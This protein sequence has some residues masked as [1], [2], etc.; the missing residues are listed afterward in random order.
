MA[1]PLPIGLRPIADLLEDPDI[2]EIMLNG[3][4]QIFVER[5]GHM[6]KVPNLKLTLEQLNVMVDAMAILAGRSVNYQS[7]YVDL[8]LPDGSRVNIILPPVSIRGPVITIRK[9]SKNFKKID[10]L[11]AKGTLDQRMAN[12][13]IAAIQGRLNVVFAGATGS[14]KTTTL[15]VLSSY[16]ETSDRIL[17]LEDTAE[18]TLNQDHV[19][20]L[21]C[22][23]ASAEGKGE[24][25]IRDLFKNAMRMRPDRII[26]GEVRG[27]EAVEMIQAMVSGHRGT[28][29]VLHAG[30]PRDVVA[31]LE[32][33]MLSADIDLP[34]FAI[35]RQIGQALDLIVQHEQIADGSRKVTNISQVTG[36]E[37]DRVTFEDLYRYRID[38][39]EGG[40]LVGKFLCTGAKP[41]FLDKLTAQ[42]V[43]LDPAL[44]VADA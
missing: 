37:N 7:P 11:I 16:I 6:L 10:D 17:T 30:S 27:G 33:M 12:L 28:L 26:V 34:L 2:S 19:V 22:R 36:V 43:K 14:G 18:L 44:F 1:T 3:A 4:N 39:V 40:R 8:S 35:H 5:R 29:G 24:V 32:V 25:T 31:R 42:G 15:N 21:E 20:N 41:V 9:F 13:L 23:A 38:G